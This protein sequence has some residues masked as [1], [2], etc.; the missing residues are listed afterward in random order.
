MVI[1][2]KRIM[3]RLVK[4]NGMVLASSLVSVAGGPLLLD[5]DPEL[6]SSGLGSNRCLRHY[7]ETSFALKSRKE[8][9]QVPRMILYLIPGRVK[10]CAGDSNKVGGLCK[11]PV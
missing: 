1:I 5:F 2:T 6:P 9:S 8:G 4:L 11:T 3:Q 10:Y 7:T